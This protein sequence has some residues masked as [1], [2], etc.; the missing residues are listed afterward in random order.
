[1]LKTLAIGVS[2]AAMMLALVT[3]ASAADKPV[4]GV[5]M[6]TLSN[7]FWG[8]MEKGV[9]AGAQQA[10]ADIF[11][12]AVE[13]DQAAEPQLNAS[14]AQ[15]PYLVGM[16]AV[17]NAKKAPA[18]EKVQEFTNV[19]TLAPTKE[20]DRGQERPDAGIRQVIGH[21]HAVRFARRTA[22]RRGRRL[23][24]F[25]REPTMS[26]SSSAVS[27]P[28]WRARLVGNA[29]FR[30]GSLIVRAALMIVMSLLPNV[31]LPVSN[32]LNILLSTAMFGV[33]AI[34][35]TFVICS[36]GIDLSVG[37]IVGFSDVVGAADAPERG[38]SK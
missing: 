33:L 37:S 25:A 36:A 7:P 19:P 30:A 23:A 11:L 20:G 28:R 21:A 9:D 29:A 27:S 3:G 4:Y 31:V 35:M 6:K 24:P 10:G 22:S 12:Q 32:F 8:A 14:V 5:L 26:A 38:A 13:S 34:G 16:Q 17:E 15:L 2:A 1:M 18:G